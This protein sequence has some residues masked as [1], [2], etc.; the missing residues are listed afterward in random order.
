MTEMSV[1]PYML[2][3]NAWAQMMA[4]QQAH[5]QL[6]AAQQAQAAQAQAAVQAQ[7]V[8][9]QAPVPVPVGH[10]PQ[11]QPVGPGPAPPI[12]PQASKQPEILTE[13]KLQEKGNIYFNSIIFSFV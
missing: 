6:V 2:G 5:A 1:P 3:P 11:F 12:M 13:D 10:V 9:A 8:H 7:T 4:Q